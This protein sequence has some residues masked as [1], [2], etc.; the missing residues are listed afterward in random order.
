MGCAS[1]NQ[2]D[3]V[4]QAQTQTQKNAIASSK[5]KD[6]TSN[7]IKDKD[8][9]TNKLI[10]SHRYS[11]NGSSNDATNKS[12]RNSTMKSCNRHGDENDTRPHT[13]QQQ[14][15]SK[16]I[17][18]KANDHARLAAALEDYDYEGSSNHTASTADSAVICIV[19]SDKLG[20]SGAGI[21]RH[22][23]RKRR[24]HNGVDNTRIIVLRKPSRRET[25]MEKVD[26]RIPTKELKELHESKAKYMSK[27]LTPTPKGTATPISTTSLKSAK[28]AS[29]S[30]LR[31]LNL[32]PRIR[33][34]SILQRK[35]SSNISE[36]MIFEDVTSKD[37][38]QMSVSSRELRSQKKKSTN[39]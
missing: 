26:E 14:R 7:D 13:R 4:C 11:Y 19:R 17:A 2:R 23:R 30:S 6:T 3:S 35:N 25:T 28:A 22:S 16:A 12:D 37:L 24:R 27:K 20:F 5:D 9:T 33:T 36:L 15:P 38:L 8:I 31:K 18:F 21:R 1:S 10:Q 32:S 29:A 39:E 34:P